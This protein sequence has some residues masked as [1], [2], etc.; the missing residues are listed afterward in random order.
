MHLTKG[1]IFKSL[2]LTFLWLKKIIIQI[3][4]AFVNYEIIH[5]ICVSIFVYV[6]INLDTYMLGTSQK[7]EFKH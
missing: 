2:L 6:S 5:F 3:V 1:L 7:F 4:G